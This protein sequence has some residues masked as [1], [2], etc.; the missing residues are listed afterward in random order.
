MKFSKET[1]EILKNFSSINLNILFKEGNR[2]VTKSPANTI[3]ADIEI[4]EDI[5]KEFG[6][7]DLS[8]FLGVL[9]LY[10]SPEIE[11]NDK[12][13]TITEGKT[14]VDYYGAEPEILTYP[15]K[16]VNF[17]A[18]YGEFNVE[19]SQIAKALKAAG[20]LGCNMFTFEGDGEKVSIVVSDPAQEG[21]N[22]FSF[23]VGETDKTF[24]AH[25]KIDNVKFLPLDYKVSLS[26]K[27]IARLQTA[28]EKTTYY[29]ALDS[30]S[31]FE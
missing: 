3:I 1:I 12:K 14:S 2:L 18:V 23:E 15:S 5:E 31:T 13:V 20:V 26:S 8:R 17:P 21:S 4:K 24:K 10:D 30:T 6:I 16:T 9:S 27:G 19:A 28:D 29:I 25:T 11:F 22:R 7:Y